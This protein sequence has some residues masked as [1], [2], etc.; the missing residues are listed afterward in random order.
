MRADRGAART[1]GF[2]TQWLLTCRS[3]EVSA[4]MSYRLKN[5]SVLGENRVRLMFPQGVQPE[6]RDIL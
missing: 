5:P 6:L 2:K 3:G 4:F 1:D